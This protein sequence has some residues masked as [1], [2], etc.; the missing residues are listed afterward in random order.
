MVRVRGRVPCSTSVDHVNHGHGAE[1]PAKSGLVP[2]LAGCQ[3]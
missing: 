1:G 3:A 2:A